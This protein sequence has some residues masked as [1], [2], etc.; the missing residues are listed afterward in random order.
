MVQTAGL[1]T[2]AVHVA[3]LNMAS[4]PVTTRITGKRS[5][6]KLFVNFN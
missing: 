5:Q 1:I 6:T 2:G 3:A 4:V